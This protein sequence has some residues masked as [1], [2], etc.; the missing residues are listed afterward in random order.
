MDTDTTA[1]GA[2]VTIRNTAGTVNPTQGWRWIFALLALCGMVLLF[3]MLFL[4]PETLRSRVG[5]GACLSSSSGTSTDKYLLLPPRLTTP[6]APAD[7][8]GPPSPVPSLR[9]LVRL[10]VYPAVG[11]ISLCTALLYAS[12]FA[13][14]VQLPVDLGSSSGKG[15]GLSSA[16]VGAAYLPSGIGM[17]VGG[18]VSGLWG[19]AMRRWRAEKMRT[20]DMERQ[21]KGGD[22]EGAVVRVTGDKTAVDVP[23]ECRLR[24]SLWAVLVLSV[25]CSLYGWLVQ[26]RVHVAAVLAATFFGEYKYT[27]YPA[28][29][30]WPLCHPI[31]NQGLILMHRI[32]GFSHS[33]VFVSTSSFLSELLPRQAAAAFSLGNMLRNPAAAVA[34]VVVGPLVERI[35][36]PG[37]CFTGL[38]LMD[39]VCVGGLLLLAVLR[40]RQWREKKAEA[41]ERKRREAKGGC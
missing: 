12:W 6:P 3:A 20:R 7:E 22:V 36:G 32:V 2:N 21:E 19:D 25:G 30:H 31:L 34:A 5:N 17:V 24:D 11:L 9:G 28:S 40:G 41:D 10:L 1:V 39:A 8:R 16:A 4:L 38:A 18:L 15:Y 23:P 35:G 14:A 26:A 13:I 37:W 29:P 27:L 33:F